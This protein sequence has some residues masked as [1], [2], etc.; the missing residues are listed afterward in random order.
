MKLGELNT[1]IIQYTFRDKS[2]SMDALVRNRCELELLHV[3]D[4]IAHEFKMQLK[5]ETESKKKGAMRD[6]YHFIII[7][8][9]PSYAFILYYMTQVILTYPKTPKGQSRLWDEK[10]LQRLIDAAKVELNEKKRTNPYLNFTRV[11]RLIENDAKLKKFASNFY[12][13]LLRYAKIARID[14]SIP[15]IKDGIV[16]EMTTGVERKN[17]KNFINDTDELD[18]IISDNARIEIISPVLKNGNY[19]WRGICDGID[20]PIEFMMMDDDFKE[21]VERD[22][23]SFQNGTCILCTLEIGRR[24]DENGLIFNNR[25]TVTL[26]SNVYKG[27]VKI[28]TP[29]GKRKREEQA[30]EKRQL[31]LFD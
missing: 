10:R 25:Y 15:V 26:V 17:F 29:K 8:G 1:F 30:A 18:S 31:S 3:V 24:M 23:I 11:C 16:T 12:F 13:Q 14:I 9:A 28:E 7:T 5:I 22:H 2:H 4:S 6:S 19:R 21:S 20:V 27:S